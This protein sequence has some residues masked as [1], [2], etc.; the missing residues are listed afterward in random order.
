MSYNY[1]VTAQEATAINAAVTGH[2]TSPSDLNLIISKNNRLEVHLVT[3]E[4][5]QPKLDLSVYGRVAT[6]QL[7]RPPVSI[8]ILYF[9]YI[10]L[11]FVKSFSLYAIKILFKYT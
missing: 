2:F 8:F 5:L 4:G 3:P 11:F 6:M 10:F 1:I 9:L 7:F